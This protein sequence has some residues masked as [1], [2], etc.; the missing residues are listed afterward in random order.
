MTTSSILRVIPKRHGPEKHGSKKHGKLR[1]MFRALL[2]SSVACAMLSLRA[3]AQDQEDPLNKVHVAPP[4]AAAPA[5]GAP[6]GAE[7]P[8]VTGSASLRVR[9]GE[10]IRMNVDMVLIPVTI[11]DPMNRLVTGL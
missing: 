4:P 6:V 1:S 3:P 7:K 10:L 5:T 8:A 9:P 11:T 2:I